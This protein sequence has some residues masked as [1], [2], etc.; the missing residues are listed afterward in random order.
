MME[1]MSLIAVVVAMGWSLFGLNAA[2]VIGADVEEPR[3]LAAATLDAAM[4]QAA[5]EA[6]AG[7]QLTILKTAAIT[8]CRQTPANFLI[9]EM[10]QK[11]DQTPG[12]DSRKLAAQW[13]KSVAEARDI[14]RFEPLSESPLP[15]GFPKTTPVGEL[16]VQNYPSYR[17]AK[18]EMTFIEGRAFWTLF[19]HI[20]GREIAMTAP[21]EMTYDAGQAPKKTSMAFMYR[22]TQQGT[23]GKDGSVEIIDIP[24]QLAVSIGVRGDATKERVSSA[25]QRLDAWLQANA[26]QY[27]A[28][29]P[30]RVMAYNSPFVADAKKFT[31]V[32]IPVRA[33]VAN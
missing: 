14:L 9:A 10:F 18:T 13:Q 4:T 27:E 16:R 7:R 31:E 32:Q 22:S 23:T 12:A 11:L 8:A 26:A 1:K 28:I 6:D 33:K 29:G 15:E 24:A 25:K 17:M 2:T 3:L 21:V 19:N 30:L 20:K 5:A